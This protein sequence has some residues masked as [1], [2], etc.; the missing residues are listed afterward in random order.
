MKLPT[1]PI[2]LE[3][4]GRLCAHLDA[5]FDERRAL[6]STLVKSVPVLQE[7]SRQT[8]KIALEVLNG[9]KKIDAF[10]KAA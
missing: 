10:P 8:I 2:N 7:R 9:A 5:S 1:P 3:N 6:K 4:P